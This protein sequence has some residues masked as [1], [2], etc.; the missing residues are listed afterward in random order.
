MYSQRA[1]AATAMAEVWTTVVVSKAISHFENALNFQL[2]HGD[3]G[4]LGNFFQSSKILKFALWLFSLKSCMGPH[5][6]PGF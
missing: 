5:S 1:L 3:L 6:T 4:Y 2:L